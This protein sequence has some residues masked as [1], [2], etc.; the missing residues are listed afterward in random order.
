VQSWDLVDD[1]G[2]PLPVNDE[3]LQAL[4]TEFTVRV[5]EEIVTDMRGPG[6]EEKKD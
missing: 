6:K 4:P 1:E 3:T 5:L 2:N